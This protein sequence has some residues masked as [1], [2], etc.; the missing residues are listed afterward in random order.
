[1]CL[2]FITFV[3]GAKSNHLP[4]KYGFLTKISSQIRHVY[5]AIMAMYHI[6]HLEVYYYSI[7]GW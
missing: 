1:M 6:S 4:L 3:I 7:S 2:F 5:V